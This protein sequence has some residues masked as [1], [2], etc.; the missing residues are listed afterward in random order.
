MVKTDNKNKNFNDNDNNNQIKKVDPPW[1]EKYRPQSTKE[2]VGFDTNIEKLKQFVI[3]FYIKLRTGKLTKKDRAILLE[4]PPGVGKTTVVHALANDLGFDIIEMN[5]SD[6]RTEAA[7]KK[8]LN[9]SV[10][11][12]NLMSFMEN[13]AQNKRRKKIILIDEVD[14][15]SGRSDRGGLATLQGIIDKTKTPIIMTSNFYDSKFK[16][17]YDR[18]E[19]IKCNSLRVTS[20]IKILKNIAAKEKIKIDGKT[21][22]KVAKNSSGDLRSA[23]NDFQGLVQGY[24]KLNLSDVDEIDLHRDTQEKIFDF[25]AS[26]FKEQTLLGARNVAS[27]ADLDYNILHNIVNANLSNFVKNDNDMRLAL[28]NLAEADVIM[29]RIKKKMDFSMLPYFFDIVSG[30]VVLSVDFPNVGGYKKFNFPRFSRTRTKFIDDPTAEILQKNFH[31]SKRDVMMYI[32]PYIQELIN[33]SG[34]ISQ[35]KS[36]SFKENIIEE[37]GFGKKEIKKYL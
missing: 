30:G 34:Q 28:M 36:K 15:I 23:I 21:L 10:G 27:N 14:G 7:I 2:M 32:M 26:M 12:M 17:L 19:K 22:E 18:V 20:I 25:I 33:I 8:K 29:G 1:F 13:G 6:A 5:A 9:E 31:L 4:G 3:N 16:T 24:I 11:T 37:F 35:A